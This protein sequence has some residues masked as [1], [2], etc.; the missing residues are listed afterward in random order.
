MYSNLG[1]FCSFSETLYN[2]IN[3]LENVENVF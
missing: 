1:F 2:N 3:D